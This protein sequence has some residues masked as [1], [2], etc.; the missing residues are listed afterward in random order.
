MPPREFGFMF[1]LV[2]ELISEDWRGTPDV[3]GEK[4]AEQDNG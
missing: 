2:T 3:N 4:L 1:M